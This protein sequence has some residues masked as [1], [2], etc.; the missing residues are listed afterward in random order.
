MNAE[1]FEPHRPRLMGIAYRM[2]GSVASA[3]DVVQE[4]WVRW[5]HAD[6]VE[7]PAAWLSTV[8]TRLCIDEARSAR[9]RRE[10]YVGPWLPEPWEGIDP[11]GWERESLTMAFLLLLQRLTAPQRAAWLL[12]EVFEQDYAHV[13]QVLDTSEAS[14][15]QLVRRARTAIAEGRPRFEPDPERQAAVVGAFQA[16]AASGDLAALERVLAHDVVHTGDGGGR[17]GAAR[18]PVHG[19]SAVARLVLGLLRKHLGDARMEPA[20][21]NGCPGVLVVDAGG[22]VVAAVVLEIADGHVRAIRNVVNPEKLDHLRS[23]P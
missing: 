11:E 17:A 2:L 22:G 7:R 20:V 13:A 6:A 9:S 10:T 15:R 1:Q 23:R 16:A 4:T 5:T 14:C 21:L 3:E 18:N 8:C 12:R 19:R